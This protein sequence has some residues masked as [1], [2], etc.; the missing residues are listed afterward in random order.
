[1]NDLLII[2]HAQHGKDT[3]AEIIQHLTGMT[4]QSSSEAASQIFLYDALKDKYGYASPL[5]CFED[6]I[7]HRTEWHNLISDFNTPDKAALAKHILMSSRMYVGMRSNAECEECLRQGLFSLVL[8]VWDPRK[9]LEHKGSFDID[10]WEKSDFI[11]PN[12][13]TLGD[14]TKRVEKLLPT[15]QYYTNYLKNTYNGHTYRL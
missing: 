11:I 15:L 14:L 8:G 12:S 2:G 5:E 3:T 13:G 6:R 9:S 7:N 10:I 1:M 4:F